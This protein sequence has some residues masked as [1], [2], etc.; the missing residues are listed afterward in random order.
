M[1]A[2]VDAHPGEDVA[3]GA[4]AKDEVDPHR[5]DEEHHQ[6]EVLVD[7]RV[8]EQIG[9]GIADQKA[10]HRVEDAD[11][12]GDDEDV[13]LRGAGEEIDQSLRREIEA[14]VFGGA[15]ESV[16]DNDE[17]RDDD[18]E[19]HEDQ[20]REIEVLPFEAEEVLHFG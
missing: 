19:D 16:E 7:L 14:S 8:G 12:E 10:D 15:G 3:R 2:P 4:G 6:H 17:D 20:I 18:E 13:D 1:V 9:D 5:H 11:E